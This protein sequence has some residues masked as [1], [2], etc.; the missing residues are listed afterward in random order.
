MRRMI[1]SAVHVVDDVLQEELSRSSDEGMKNIV[2]TIQPI[3]TG[4]SEG[5]VAAGGGDQDD[6]DAEREV[7]R[8]Q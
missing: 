5:P 4:V 7:G 2:A 8:D 1:D 3:R 6:D